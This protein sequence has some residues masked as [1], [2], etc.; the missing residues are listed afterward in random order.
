MTA[1]YASMRTGANVALWASLGE[2]APAVVP[3][4]PVG[5]SASPTGGTTADFSLT[6][7]N[8]GIAQY[9]WQMRPVG[10]TWVDAIGGTNPP[11]PGVTTFS[12]AGGTPA[13]EFEA[14]ARAESAGGESAWVAAAL[15]FFFDNS[16]SGTVVIGASDTTAPTLSGDIVI[17]GLSTTGYTATCPPASDAVGVTGYQ[18]RLG[19]SGAWTDIPSGGRTQVFTGR[20]PA[21]T[22]SLEMRAR[23]AAGNFS[24]PLSTPVTLQGIAPAVTQQPANA[25]VID[26]GTATFVAAFS[27]TP[28]PSLQWYRNGV[29]ISGATSSTYGLTASISDS[30]SVFVCRGSNT[31]GFIDS[32]AA[33]LTVTAAAVAPSVITQPASQ[34]VLPS[35][36]VTFSV[37]AGGSSPIAYQWRRNGVD[38]TGATTASYA[39]TPTGADNGALFTVRVSNAAG[40][41]VSQA[42]T[43]SITS[44]SVGASDPTI[45]IPRGEWSLFAYRTRKQPRETCDIVIEMADW[46]AGRSDS[47]A[48]ATFEVSDPALQA[49]VRL[50]GTRIY[51]TAAAGLDGTQYRITVLMSTT[52]VPAIVREFDLF[53][54]VVE[55]Q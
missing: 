48:S 33:V 4:A 18:W 47:P 9:R 2:A 36:P 52:S 19:G 5:V 38:I 26:G 1:V 27:G 12:A 30:G 55:V 28:A 51:I 22:D 50:I 39:F 16:A 44:G 53:V 42:A 3:S 41:I 24:S 32:N 54:Q 6:D 21:S 46:F 49:T 35:T 17:T 40:S 7:T 15:P 23:D 45:S 37:V 14:R 29:P 25:S 31:T 13:G 10:G 11:A 20:T 34:S 43:L 8:L